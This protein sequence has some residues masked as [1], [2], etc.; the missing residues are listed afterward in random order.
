[1]KILKRKFT[2]YCY[3]KGYCYSRIG[4]NAPFYL[5]PIFPYCFSISYYVTLC[6]KDLAKGFEKGIQEYNGQANSN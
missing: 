5:K 4:I 2:K 6:G 1:M 3:K